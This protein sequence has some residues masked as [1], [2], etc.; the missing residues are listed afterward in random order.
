MSS[1]V[2]PQLDASGR[3]LTTGYDWGT[4]LDYFDLAMALI[5]G[6]NAATYLGQ[7]ARALAYW[8]GV[9]AAGTADSNVLLC[10]G[11]AVT[12][13]TAEQT[14]VQT[15]PNNNLHIVYPV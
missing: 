3:F 14:R 13:L 6:A 7:I 9:V 10:A 5:P 11:W 4:P 15:P 12:W 1:A 2:P 8:Q